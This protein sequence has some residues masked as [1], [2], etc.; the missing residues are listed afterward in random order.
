MR[1][2]NRIRTQKRRLLRVCVD[3]Y[4]LN[5]MTKRDVYPIARMDKLINFLSRAAVFSTLD[6][7][8]GYS[9]VEIK[10]KHWEKKYF[11]SHH[12]IYRFVWAAFRLGFAPS[13]FQ[14][15][16]DVA[17][18]VIKW[19]FAFDY[20]DNIVV[21]SRSAAEQMDHVKHV[22]TLSREVEV[23]LKVQIVTFLPK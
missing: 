18:S 21:L 4:K 23:I 8:S 19:L 14:R 10:N 3:D 2:S 17:L 5:A 12:G 16:I 1:R 13:T 9:Q 11:T 6:A 15:A 22:L 20:I 7:N